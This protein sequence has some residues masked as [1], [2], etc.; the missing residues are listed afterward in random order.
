M[1]FEFVYAGTDCKYE[2]GWIY[3]KDGYG[4][5]V[6][7][8]PGHYALTCRTEMFN[9]EQLAIIMGSIIHGY[10]YGSNKG[11]NEL[12]QEVKNLFALE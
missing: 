7:F 10:F 4:V 6:K 1:S 11:K 2:N 5:W 9:I 8:C 3:Q 12:K